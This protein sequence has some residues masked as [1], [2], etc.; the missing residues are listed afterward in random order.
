[1]TENWAPVAGFEGIY[2]VSDLGRVRRV[3]SRQGATAGQVIQAQPQ[4]GGYLTV[5]LRDRD[6]EVRRTL[7]T[8]VAI[9]FI[10]NPLN[11][12]EVN[13]L[14]PKSDCRASMLEWRTGK[15]NKLHEV[16]SNQ[17]GVSFR[18]DTGKYVARYSN[19]YLGS[20]ATEAEARAARNA[21]V[22][23]LPYIL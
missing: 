1:M 16:Q 5:H 22:D 15:G 13:H 23:A 3:E 21:A 10:P 19:D 4:Q 12:P 8:L 6:T 11:L 18:K 14:G 17:K 9:A 20:F 2:E 7:H